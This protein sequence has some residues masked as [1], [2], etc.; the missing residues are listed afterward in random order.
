MSLAVF[1]VVIVAGVM[2]TTALQPTGDID[3]DIAEDIA[4]EGAPLSS[5]EPDNGDR[6]ASDEIYDPQNPPFSSDLGISLGNLH[7]QEDFLR[8]GAAD[9]FVIGGIKMRLGNDIP[10]G[11]TV[12]TKVEYNEA[13]EQFE[14]HGTLSFHG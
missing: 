4:I 8:N 9:L 3:H 6:D 14:I 2:V 13:G 11:K 7:G 10:D 5:G 12:T 1:I